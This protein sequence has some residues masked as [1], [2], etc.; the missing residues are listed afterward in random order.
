MPSPATAPQR[1]S[2]APGTTSA[3]VE[4][5]LP[6]NGVQQYVVH[7][8]ASQLMEVS[9][10]PQERLRLSVVGADGKVLLS[11]SA[12]IPFFR[13]L[14]PSSQDY[15]LTVLARGGATPYSLNVII[16]AR[17]SF[18]AGTT[19]ATVEGNLAANGVQ[20]Y[21]LGITKGQLLDVTVSPEDIRLSIYG[22]DG[23]VLMSGM[24][25]GSAFRG[26]VPISEDYI[27]ALSAENG[28]TPYSMQVIIP[29]RISFAPG[30][31]SAE[32]QGNLAINS[33]QYYVIQAMAGQL[34]EVGVSPQDG[35]RLSIYGVDGTVLASGMASSPFFRGTLPST[36]DYIIALI[37]EPGPVSYTMD[38]IIPQRI[39]FAPGAISATVQGQVAAH[40][41]QYYILGASAGQKMDVTV[42]PEGSVRLSIY[43]VD[44]DVLWSGMGEGSSFQG[45]LPTTQDYIVAIGGGPQPVAYTLQV[46]IQ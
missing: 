36:Q 28:A 4:G 41:A 15:I 31:T 38:V 16:P 29:A 13:G 14:V 46:T 26:T 19:S 35:V 27:V 44:G 8:E 12:A 25:G 30:A 37:A 40:G 17:I 1:I 2:F 32:V 33:V 7:V 39:S 10:T 22:V 43:G 20:Y 11:D 34:M 21:V 6:A 9:V 24:G 23:T 45:T 18:A 3:A 5:D 42:T